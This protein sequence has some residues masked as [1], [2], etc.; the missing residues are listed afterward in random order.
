MR[1]LH[2]LADQMIALVSSSQARAFVWG[3]TAY[4][5]DPPVDQPEDENDARLFEFEVTEPLEQKEDVVGTPGFT[6]AVE[7]RVLP[8]G[9]DQANSR[10]GLVPGEQKTALLV[11]R[12]EKEQS[13]VEHFDSNVSPMNL[14]KMI[15]SKDCPLQ[16]GNLSPTDLEVLAAHG[17]R[18]Q[19]RGIFAKYDGRIRE[20]KAEQSRMEN[21]DKKGINEKILRD[22][23]KILE[24]IQHLV[25]ITYD[26]LYPS[27]KL[28]FDVSH[29][30][31]VTALLHQDYPGLNKVA[32]EVA[33]K[34]KPDVVSDREFQSLKGKW[35][36]VKGY[37]EQNPNQSD[38]EHRNFIKSV[39]NGT[40]DQASA[41]E[42]AQTSS[43]RFNWGAAA[44]P[45]SPTLPASSTWAPSWPLR[46]SGDYSDATTNL[47]SNPTLP[48]NPTTRISDPEFVLQLQTMQQTYPALSGLMRKVHDAL[49]RNLETL[50][51]KVIADQLDRIASMERRRQNSAASGARG[52]AYREGL[53]R[54]FE[55]VM[56]ELR[57]AMVSSA[58]FVQ[59]VRDK[60]LVAVSEPGRTHIFIE[61]SA[62][63]D[64]AVNATHGKASLSH[65][66]FGGPQRKFAFDQTTRLLAVVHGN[67]NDLKLSIYIFDEMFANLQSRSSPISLK[68][69]YNNRP[70]DLRNICFV[71]GVEEVCLVE[72]S[73]RVRIF[74]LVTQQFRAVSLQI[75]RPIVDAFS[76]PDGSCL[77]VVVPGNHSS[78]HRLLAFHWAS[79]GTNKR[80]ID[81]TGL[82]GCDGHRVATRFDGR[83]RVHVVSFDAASRA[84]TSTVLQI[85][86]KANDFSFRKKGIKKINNSLIDCHLE[87]WRQFPVVPAVARNTPIVIDRQPREL[88]FASSVGLQGVGEYFVGVISAF[89]NTSWK[90]IGETLT[91]MRARGTSKF[92]R[93]IVD[94]ISEFKLGSFIVELLCLIPLHLAVMRGNHFIPL[95]DGVW[96]PEYE[97]SL[98][99]ADVPGIVDALSLGCLNHLA[100]TSFA[101]SAMRAAEGIW[102]SCTP[103]DEHLLVSL[104]FKGVHSTR[105]TTQEDALLVLFNTAISNLVLFHD[106]FAIS[107]N[108][109]NLF[110]SFQSSATVIDPNVNKRLFNSTLVIIIKDVTN[111]DS[112][113]IIKKLSLEFQGTVEKERDRNFITRLHRGHIQIVPWPS[114]NSHNFYTTLGRL[115]QKLNQ[116]P[117]THDSCGA[118]LHNLKTLMA[119]VTISDWGS[120]D[121]NVAT[122]RAHQLMERLPN[123]LSCGRLEEG[124]LK[125]RH[126]YFNMYADMELDIPDYMPLLFI[127]EFTTGKPVES[128]GS[129]E[130][131]LRALIKSCGQSIGTRHQIPD[132]SYVEILQKSLYDSLDQ[133]L[134]LVQKWVDVNIE[135][136]PPGNRDIR[137]LTNK[138]HAAS[139]GTM[140][141]TAAEPVIDVSLTVRSSR[142]IRNATHAAYL[143]VTEEGIC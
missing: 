53:Q 20:L 141:N 93:N 125:A 106:N 88:V 6:I 14:K 117:F 63:I 68:N 31:E 71:S 48:S 17:L 21:P 35:G 23:P 62:T 74:S 103:T 69:W 96:D 98:L 133:R 57:E 33:R 121:Q 29:D 128:A 56:R 91:A 40:Y 60:C 118:F 41:R 130:E 59:L 94:K 104:N 77:L 140:A 46:S 51:N 134:A 119:K 115:R 138:L 55:V 10:V 4:H 112:K 83:G 18:S 102:L 143:L 132:T 50:E 7:S 122:H 107:T 28:M 65:D 66:A 37:L 70:I 79:F 39:L 3:E 142:T 129:A 76:A 120:M 24:E 25:R 95:K 80:G 114:A 89:E 34:Q 13:E 36:L 100:D 86:Q 9:H 61:N 113:E 26:K 54:T 123:A 30:P 127:P 22:R 16:L 135:C 32:D 139:I 105:R 19:H 137:N 45:T 108:I 92:G 11:V 126:L 73:G 97:R 47:G 87:V 82:G 2:K 64:H 42:I 15:E 81:S 43:R 111:A 101:G 84:L 38:D 49:G 72:T 1:Y 8:Q 85:T 12:H 67:E 78:S 5:E 109:L 110:K 27:L 90:P 44:W 58:W 99:G 116:Q 136:F 124:P 131:A 52:H 75:D